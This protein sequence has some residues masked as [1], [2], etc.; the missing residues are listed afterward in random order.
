MNIRRF[1][2]CLCLLVVS[3]LCSPCELLAAPRS[4]IKAKSAIVMNAVSGKILYIKN[5]D[6]QMP[7]A[8]LTK[9][10]TLYLVQEAVN[11][12]KIKLTDMVKISV[13]AQLTGG[14][15]MYLVDDNEVALDD[16]IKGITIVSANDA[17]VAVAEYLGG[18]V[19]KFVEMMNARARELGMKHSRFMNPHGLPVQGHVSTAR[20]ILTLSNAFIRDFPQALHIHSMKE[21]QFRG[22]T[23][24]N[25]NTLIKQHSD[26]DGLKTGFVSASGFHV[27][28]T[29]KR[30]NTRIIA[31]VMGEKNIKIREQEAL[32][33]LEEGF[34]RTTRKAKVSRHKIH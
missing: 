9:I 33:L 25:S 19:E 5:P 16:L 18:N 17:S 2:L 24:E 32:Q 27:V 28:A 26:V 14:S 10:L 7:P 23:Q 21:Y 1:A 6:K 20:D 22:I 8:S 31:V 4:K 12:G 3:F 30:E 29:A 13:N 11:T 15:S 34:R